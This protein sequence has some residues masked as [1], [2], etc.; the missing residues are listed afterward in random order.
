MTQSTPSLGLLLVAALVTSAPARAEPPA[1]QNTD[2]APAVTPVTGTADTSAAAAAPMAAEAVVAPVTAAPSNAA[3][4][5]N[6]A[7]TP[8][9]FAR[10]EYGAVLGQVVIPDG[11]RDGSDAYGVQALYGFPI[12]SAIDL[13]IHGGSNYLRRESDRRYDV[14]YHLGLALKLNL[15]RQADFSPFL[16]GGLG[17]TREDEVNRQEVRPFADIGLGFTYPIAASNVAVRAETR[18]HLVLVDEVAAPDTY[19][20]VRFNLGLQFGLEQ[21][22]PRLTDT[23]NDGVVDGRDR[24]PDT[25]LGTEIDGKGC[26]LPPADS[27]ADGVPDSLDRCPGTPPGSTVDADGCPPPPAALEPP[28]PIPVQVI[29]TDG[30]G[31]LDGSDS[32]PNTPKGLRV[33]ATGCLV[34]Q[35]TVLNDVQFEYDSSRLTGTAMEILKGVAAS[36]KTQPDLRVE[37]S[38]HTDSLGPQAYNLNLSLNR[39]KAVEA[40]LV[41]EGVEASRLRVEGY[42]EFI[43]VASNDTEAGRLQNRR[44]EFKIMP[45][46]PASAP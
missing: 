12:T 3:S 46:T 11:E 32:C 17:A 44:V 27:D 33:D 23:D 5:R 8:L 20:D 9:R 26:P 21:R 10:G 37:V 45:P 34:A 38:G 36:L 15:P 31:V 7:A 13:E 18:Y 19:G 40:F 39:A 43:P 22:G 35:T 29:D 25:P 41:S 1:A 14:F 16:I 28:A 42:G 24:C 4:T 30:D 2:A 6:A